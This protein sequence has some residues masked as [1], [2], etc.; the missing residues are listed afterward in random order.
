M[1][2]HNR[3]DFMKLSTAIGITAAVPNIFS[4][5]ER[6]R[7]D[8]PPNFII[9][10]ADDLGYGDLG[11]YG[12]KTI[13]TPN[14][15]R[16]AAEGM[17]FSDFSVTCSVCSPSRASLL[18]GRYPSRCGMPFAVGG[19]YSDVGLQDD[20][21]TIAGLLKKQ[22]YSTACIGKWHLG[23]PQG[24]N[25]QTHEG[26]TSDS[27][28]HPNR[29]GFDLFFGVAGNSSPD[30]SLV[31]LEN[32]GIV[33]IDANITTSTEHYTRNAI[34]FIRENK[35]KPFFIYFPH[36][37][38][39]FPMMANPR[40]E[41]KSR[42]G[43]YGDL[44]EEIDWSTGEI[45]QALKE[46]DLDDN[47]LVIFTSDNGAANNPDQKYGS[48]LPFRNGKGS[49]FEGGFREPAIFRW[50]G[51]IPAGEVID[52]MANSMD[53]LPTLANLAGVKLPSDRIID[54]A[55]IWSLLSGDKSIQWPER[56]FFYYNGLN[57]Q[58]IRQ[59]KWKLHLPRTPE[60][61]VWWDGG[62]RE[63]DKPILFNL[64]ADPGETQ[65][66]AA[67][68][69]DIVKHLLKLTKN[70]RKELGSWKKKGSDQKQIEHLMNDRR[71]LRHLR[72]HQN[73]QNMGK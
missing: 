45:L 60:M 41:G 5:I 24:F 56:T 4:C 47:T 3:R 52:E 11:C 28:F 38:P 69:P 18:T 36:N 32:D 8:R 63:L 37:R 16:M 22:N 53:L 21:I 46:F 30:G 27:E 9:I 19:V 23:I 67:E 61:L 59:G 39:H 51:K 15:D 7:S 57:L 13:Q 58:A 54:G 50:P 42:A 20:E 14:L 25:Y 55:D 65:D 44:V 62:Q 2:C 71:R 64:D 40:F 49:T 17:R 35:D 70:V 33:E 12:S 66:V 68:Y 31:L 29:Q 43:V 6:N 1:K 10:F 73:H 26:F 72:T 48:N 34:D